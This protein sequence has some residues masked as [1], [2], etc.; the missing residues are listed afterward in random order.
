MQPI[1]ENLGSAKTK[2]GNEL[3]DLDLALGYTFPDATSSY[4]ERDVSLY[5]LGVGAAKD[6]LDSKELQTVYELHGDGMH[7]LPTFGVTPAL[8]VMMKMAREGK[9]A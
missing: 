4:D 2:G 8:N 7:V 9:Q 5:A 6:P 3:I 1:L